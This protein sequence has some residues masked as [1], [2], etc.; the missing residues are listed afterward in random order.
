MGGGALHNLHRSNKL[1][2]GSK[3]VVGSRRVIQRDR[4]NRGTSRGRKKGKRSVGVI[5]AFR[6]SLSA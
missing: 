6:I 3:L 1:Q 4:L 2:G 5:S